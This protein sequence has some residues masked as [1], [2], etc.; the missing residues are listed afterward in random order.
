MTYTDIWPSAVAPGVIILSGFGIVLFLVLFVQ[1]SGFIWNLVCCNKSTNYKKYKVDRMDLTHIPTTT[2][3]EREKEVEREFGRSDSQLQHHILDSQHEAHE[4][5]MSR[6]RRGS[7]RVEH[8]KATSSISAV[9][10]LTRRPTG[11]GIAS[12]N[13]KATEDDY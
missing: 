3:E 4:R 6:L 7:V 9:H 2:V 12:S 13:T 8:L 1:L 5:L 11:G 10:P